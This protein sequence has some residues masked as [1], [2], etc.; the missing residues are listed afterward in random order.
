M[1]LSCSSTDF[2]ND[3]DLTSNGF[4]QMMEKT[5]MRNKRISS[6]TL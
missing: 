1:T 5:G 6:Q 4:I 2:E 3:S